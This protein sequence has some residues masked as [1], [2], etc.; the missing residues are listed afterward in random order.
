MRVLKVVKVR[1]NKADGTEQNYKAGVQLENAAKVAL[2]KAR[3]L[4]VKNVED[5]TASDME[6]RNAKDHIRLIDD[7]LEYL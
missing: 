7:A 6:K 3:A 1:R 2:Q 5:K 4:F